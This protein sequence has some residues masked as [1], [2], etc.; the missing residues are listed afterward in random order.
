M[1]ILPIDEINAMEDR[2]K[3]H[4]DDGEDGKPG[5]GRIK[6]REDCE[7]IIDELEDLFLLSYAMGVDS[8]NSIAPTQYQPTT[9]DIEATLYERIEGKTWVDR[10]WDY[11]ENGGTVYDIARI[12]ATEAHRDTNAAAYNTAA[13]TGAKRSRW[14]CM[15]LES[16]RDT[17]VYLNGVTAPIGGY[18][19]SYKGGRTQYPGQ[20][21][22]ADEDCNCLC[23]LT[24]EW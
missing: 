4:F 23:W 9:D 6:S 13:R 1:T 14:N 16:S 22:I 10:V 18:Y 15:M 12:A 17:H 11:Y 7:D 2:L 21:G 24:F 3:V 5:T 20:W 19:Y 8:V